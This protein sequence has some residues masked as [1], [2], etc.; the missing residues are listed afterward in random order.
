MADDFTAVREAEDA[1]RGSYV[2]CL[3]YHLQNDIEAL[4][5]VVNSVGEPA[6][7]PGLSVDQRGDT[8]TFS[9]DG[10]GDLR[11]LPGDGFLVEVAV[12]NDHQLV[13]P[14]GRHSPPLDPG[15]AHGP[16]GAPGGAGGT[17]FA[18]PFREQ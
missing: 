17:G 9:F 4:P 7:A 3:G 8:A 15:V 1:V 13:G 10:A 5:L 2:A 11:Q 12:E 18:A 6:T 14:H 16:T